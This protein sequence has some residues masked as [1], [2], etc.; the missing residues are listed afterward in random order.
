MFPI[1]VFAGLSTAGDID[2]HSAAGTVDAAGSD[3][4]DGTDHNSTD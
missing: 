1:M 3:C 4:A 2:C